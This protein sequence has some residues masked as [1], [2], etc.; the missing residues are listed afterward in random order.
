VT[1]ADLERLPAL[2]RIYL[3]RVGV[4]SKPRVKAFRARFEGTL[5]GSPGSGFMDVEV[6]QH[7]FFD[8]AARYFVARGSRFGVPFAAFHRYVGAEA[9][10][11]V[12]VAS[13]FDVVDARGSEMNQSET[14]TLFNDMC[15]LAPATL[16]DAQVT[17]QTVG[18]RAL[19]GTFTN[20]GHTISADLSFDSRGDLENFV[21]DDRYQSADGKVYEKLR[22]STP[23]RDYRDFGGVRLAARGDAV[24]T[25]KDGNFPYARFELK[26]IE[27]DPR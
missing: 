13:L 23:V 6:E 17:W 16:V 2:L 4:V 3:E 11:R 24:W 1:A 20:A 5:K 25:E 21:S 26:E 15:L 19:R 18:V 22:W 10:M 8:P 27:Y 12:R 9:T 7:E 14:V